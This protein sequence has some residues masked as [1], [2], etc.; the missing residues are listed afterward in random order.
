MSDIDARI[1]ILILVLY[2]ASLVHVA[3]ESTR[4]KRVGRPV[5]HTLMVAIVLW[6]MSYLCWILWWP[7]SF[8]QALFGSDAD[9]IRRKLRSDLARGSAKG[10]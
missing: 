5:L 9:R 4:N 10:S 3:L 6:P 7:G 8:R 2:V 1:Q